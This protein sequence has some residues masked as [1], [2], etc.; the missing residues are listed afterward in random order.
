MSTLKRLSATLFTRIDHM[1]SQVENH[2]AVI[3]SA[4]RDVRQTAARARVRL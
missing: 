1:V 4:V 3:E 2:D